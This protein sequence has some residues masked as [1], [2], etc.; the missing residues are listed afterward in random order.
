MIIKTMQWA[1]LQ[2]EVIGEEMRGEGARAEPQLEG[3]EKIK[4]CLRRGRTDKQI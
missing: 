2:R 3:A 4:K 1:W